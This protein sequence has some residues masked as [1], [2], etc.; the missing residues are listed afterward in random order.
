MPTKNN[1]IKSMFLLAIFLLT[2]CSSQPKTSIVTPEKKNPEWFAIPLSDARSG[3][4]FA[5]N[6]FL[7]EVVLVETMA[8]WCPNCIIQAHEVQKMH[9]LL[10]NPED[11]VSI[12]LDIDVNEDASGLKDYVSEYG[13]EW[14]FAIAPLE[15]ARALGNLYGANYLNPPLSPMLVIDRNG[16]VHPLDHGKKSAEMLYESLKPFLTP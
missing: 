8:M 3:E 5:M 10:D 6:D 11:V 9:E 16:E 14:R 12:S 2:A 15:I 1:S 7:G 4:T 13:F